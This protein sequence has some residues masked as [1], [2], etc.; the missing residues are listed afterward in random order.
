MPQSKEVHKEYMRQRRG[1]QTDGSQEI[2]RLKSQ[3]RKVH[4]KGSQ[5]KGSQVKVHTYE[6]VCKNLD[7]TP[8]MRLKPID[9][10]DIVHLGGR[11]YYYRQWEGI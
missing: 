4:S 3:A 5:N 1:S 11:P 2:D 6:E 10:N 7:I 9:S 8:T